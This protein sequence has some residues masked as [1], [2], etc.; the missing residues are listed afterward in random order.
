MF[1]LYHWRR[2]GKAYLYI[3]FRFIL[4]GGMRGINSIGMGL[5][6]GRGRE[7]N[8]SQGLT[9]APWYILKILPDIRIKVITGKQNQHQVGRAIDTSPTPRRSDDWSGVLYF[10]HHSS[11]SLGCHCSNR[12]Y[13]QFLPYDQCLRPRSIHLSKPDGGVPTDGTLIQKVIEKE[14]IIEGSPLLF[15]WNVSLER[16]NLLRDEL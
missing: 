14:G 2:L 16:D 13:G 3:C 5:K 9:K 15:S 1:N 10:R 8:G 7:S 12:Y 11:T 4:T 6:K